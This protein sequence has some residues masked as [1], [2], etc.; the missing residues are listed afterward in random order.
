MRWGGTALGRAGAVAWLLAYLFVLTGCLDDPP[1]PKQIF[2]F[3]DATDSDLSAEVEEAIDVANAAL[4][5]DGRFVLR[6]MWRPGRPQQALQQVPVYLLRRP[7]AAID[8]GTATPDMLRAF[9]A[10]L[11]RTV[12]LSGFGNCAETDPCAAAMYAGTQMGRAATEVY[13]GS[14]AMDAAAAE[15][16]CRC[17][18]LIED[19]LRQ[20]KLIFG[21]S[22]QYGQ[23]FAPLSGY[24]AWLALHEAGHLNRTFRLVPGA[25]W[26]EL[27]RRTQSGLAERQQEEMRADAYAA[28]LLGRACFAQVPQRLHAIAAQACYGLTMQA[29]QL[30]LYEAFDKTDGGL[31]RHYLNDGR[32]HPN[33]LMRLLAAN[34]VMMDGRGKSAE[35]LTKFLEKREV[36]AQRLPKSPN[37]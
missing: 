21:P 25:P 24:V 1:D 15:I 7:N 13:N 23:A 12:S 5:L 20:F 36:V 6:P 17:V 9:R 19:N 10:E 37:L 14:T 35:L 28:S 31:R 26:A 8:A 33:V 11:A 2:G 29:A 32:T 18:M 3:R 34:V 22:D 16:N 27:Y 4:E 30:W